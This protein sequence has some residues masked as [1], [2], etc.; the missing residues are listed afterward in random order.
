[1]RTDTAAG[2][3]LDT[4]WATRHGAQAL[5]DRQRERLRRLVTVARSRSPFYAEH[6]RGAPTDPDHVRQLPVV[7]KSRLMDDFDRWVCDPSVTRAGVEAFI[8]DPSRVGEPFLGRYLVWTT[9]GTSGVRA[10]LVQDRMA[11]AVYTPV[12]VVRGY[13]VSNPPRRL[14]LDVARVVRRGGRVAALLATGGHYG[15]AVMVARSHRR[16][17]RLAARNRLFSVLQPLDG[18]VSDLNR[19]RPAVLH[20]Y[21]SALALLAEEELAG[22]LHIAP[23]LIG[24]TGETLTPHARRLIDTAFGCRVRDTYGASESGGIAFECSHRQLHVNTDWV[25]LEPVDAHY[26]RVP[27]GV[28]SDTVLVTNLANRVQPIIRYDLG[29]SVTW[30]RDPCRCGSP[31][32]VI[33][34]QGR[35]DEVVTLAGRHGLV[36]VLPLALTTIAEQ[37]PGLRMVQ[38]VTRHPDALTVRCEPTTDDVWQALERR[39][40]AFLSDQGADETMLVRSVDAPVCDAS[41]KYRSVVTDPGG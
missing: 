30:H 16:H 37:T 3:F 32:P 36:R 38:Y 31:L 29:D 1:M 18:L 33:T 17:P 40:G 5:V 26:Q 12:S 15:G 11:L 7:T 27:P 13:L 21:P 14:F 22:R 39:L 8:A 19:F 35:S 24:A 28:A 6:L 10:V 9:S 2:V 25:I 41:G 34:V 23:A 4:W 20:G